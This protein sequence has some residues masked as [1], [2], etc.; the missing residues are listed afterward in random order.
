MENGENNPSDPNHLE[1]TGCPSKGKTTSFHTQ[2][3]QT[4]QRMHTKQLQ[5]L[6]LKENIMEAKTTMAVGKQH[7]YDKNQL[8]RTFNSFTRVKT[9]QQPL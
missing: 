8:H 1:N 5:V 2:L 9:A 6:G 3:I 7:P 4:K